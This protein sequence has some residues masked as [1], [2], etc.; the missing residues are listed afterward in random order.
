MQ[1]ETGAVDT[2]I[3][4]EGSEQPDLSGPYLQVARSR[5]P[6]DQMTFQ[7]KLILSVTK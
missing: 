1:I 3:W 7:P 5:W 2:S 4:L 6:A